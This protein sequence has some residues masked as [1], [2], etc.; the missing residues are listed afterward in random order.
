MP[1]FILTSCSVWNGL[2]LPG[3]LRFAAIELWR[4]LNTWKRQVKRVRCP[5]AYHRHHQTGRVTMLPPGLT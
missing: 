5:A 3:L 1:A 4:R 2:R